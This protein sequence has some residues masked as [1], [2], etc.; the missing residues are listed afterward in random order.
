MS[1][2]TRQLHQTCTYWAQTGTDMEGK[3]SFSAKVELACRWEDRS[4]LILSKRGQE[5][6]SRSRVYLA[7]EVD[8]NGYLYLGTTAETNPL[9]LSGACEVQATKITPDLRNLSNLYVA[10]L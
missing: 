9:V 5:I 1:Q 10:F 7:A 4:E 8:I 2:I 3:P 6:V